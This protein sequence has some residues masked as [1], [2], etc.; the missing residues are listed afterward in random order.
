MATSRAAPL[1]HCNSSAIIRE[2]PNLIDNADTEIAETTPAQDSDS[3]SESG[4]ED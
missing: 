1:H 3:D 2:T 4:E